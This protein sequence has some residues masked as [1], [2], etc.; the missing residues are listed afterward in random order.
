LELVNFFIRDDFIKSGNLFSKDDFNAFLLK[1]KIY[2]FSWIG[3]K[4]FY[5]EYD[6]CLLNFT[7]QWQEF[8]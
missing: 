8:S 4:I 2:Q 7:F 3:M 6:Q 5:G 1:F